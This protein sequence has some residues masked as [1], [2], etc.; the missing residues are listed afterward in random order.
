MTIFAAMKEVKKL[1][2]F[3]L[4][5]PVWFY[6]YFIS[7]LTGASCRHVPT[8]SQYAIDAVRNTGPVRGFILATNR[9]LRCRPGGTHGFDPAP[10]IWVKRYGGVRCCTNRYPFSKRLKD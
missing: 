5:L 9:F 10:R 8:C 4:L 3:I 6:R 2:G 7:P 1:A